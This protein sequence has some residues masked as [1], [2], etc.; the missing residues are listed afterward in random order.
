MQDFDQIYS[1]LVILKE[2]L[3]IFFI[4]KR[5]C[6]GGGDMRDPQIIKENLPNYFI[7]NYKFICIPVFDYLMTDFIKA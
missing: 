3:Q 1:T 5:Q 4:H 6:E 2:S 7:G